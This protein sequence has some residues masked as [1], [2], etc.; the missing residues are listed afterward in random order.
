[1]KIFYTL[2]SISFMF[3][4]LNYSSYGQIADGTFLPNFEGVDINGEKHDLYDI[5]SQ[6]YKVVIDVSATWCG[7]CW[8]YHVSG[9]LE[10][11][12]E[13]YGPDG[14]QEIFV[15]FIEGDDST[16]NDDL[17][18]VGESTFGDW[19]A[20]TAYPMIDNAGYI[21]EL[22]EIAYYPTV[23]T[24]CSDGR[25]YE[26][27]QISTA[28]HYEFAM[29][30]D[31]QAKPIDV[32][33]GSMKSAGFCE[34]PFDVEIDLIN[35]GLETLQNAEITMKGCDACPI[36]QAWTGDLAYFNTDKLVFSGIGTSDP[37]VDLTFS[38]DNMDGNTSNNSTS[39]NVKIE[40][41]E[42]TT[43]WTIEVNTDCYPSENSWVVE[44]TDGVVVASSEVFNVVDTM[45]TAIVNLPTQDCY[46]FIFKD[47]Y[48]DG[49][50]GTAVPSCG[51]DGS[52]I[53]YSDKGTI[54]EIDGVTQFSSL[55]A[56]SFAETASSTED[57][58]E[59]HVSIAPNPVSDILNVN[60]KDLQTSDVIIEMSDISGKRCF[61]KN[62][63][64]ANN[65]IS[66]RINVSNL[67]SGIYL[68]KIITENNQIA[69]KVIVE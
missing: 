25:I 67:E 54:M 12:Y 22:L 28:D 14:T 13:E 27:G 7:P 58:I 50:N 47:S 11:L 38:I 18:G 60:L 53:C 31:C 61:I 55:L 41:I 43:E 68:L 57:L 36:T 32:A 24:V 17:I 39:H 34:A 45:Y 10:N 2:I 37:S 46:R 35:S 69:K 40:S 48:G 52:A 16:T 8:N 5:L 9:T 44:N 1:M 23:Y 4:S 30:L 56:T 63:R 3:F 26:S 59:A 21:A 62:I 33:V 6:G 49:L 19:T 15:L 64:G 29:A 51:I 20:G 66:E 65:D 42:S